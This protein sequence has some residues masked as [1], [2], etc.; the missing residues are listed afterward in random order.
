MRRRVI[1]IG[2][3]AA[4]LFAAGQAVQNGA[5][6]LILEKMNQPG[7][8]LRITGKGRCNLT[9]VASLSD[10]MSHFGKNGNF[11]RQAFQSFF[12]QE[13]IEF[14][15]ELSIPTVTERG[16]RV[17]PENQQAPYIAEK[18]Q[19]WVIR[20]GATIKT[21][22]P[23]ERLIVKENRIAGIALAAQ[24]RK[25]ADERR[26]S[27]PIAS[28]DRIILATG[29]ASYPATGSTGDGYRMAASIGHTIAPIRPALVPI[30]TRGDTARRLKGLH[31]RNITARLIINGKKK[32]EAFGEMDFTDFGVSGPIILTLSRKIVDSLANREKAVL[33]IDL[34]PALSESQLDARLLRDLD[35]R[36]RWSFNQLLK[37]LLPEKLIP[38]CVD[39]TGIPKDK[40]GHQI[41]SGE[42]RRVRSWLK[43]FCLEIRGSRPFSEAIITAGG[44]CLSEV[45]PRT[46][47]SRLIRNLYF[48]GEILDIDADTGGYNL[49]AAFSTGW[50]AGRSAA[51][52]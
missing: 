28:E 17:F 43:D 44:V 42:R 36:G 26:A 46:M 45:N 10:F 25:A 27:I 31:L 41:T 38:V 19:E 16:G 3:G 7:R 22:H 18:L 5:E 29:G 51:L 37:G 4:G 24:S 34:K 30:E 23:V 1:I 40:T 2:G 49:Q 33:S 13:L 35:T 6:T 47:V 8:K 39:Q 11:L 9:N 48:A 12:S 20:C 15:N 14:L 52:E 32:S 21:L 50:L